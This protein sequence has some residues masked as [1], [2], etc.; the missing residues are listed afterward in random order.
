VQTRLRRVCLALL[1]AA[2]FTVSGPPAAP[3]VGPAAVFPYE[4]RETTL[5]NGLRLVVIP[6]D[7]PGTIAYYTLVRTGSRDDVDPGHSGFAHFFEHMMFRGT[8]KYPAERYKG[9]LRTMGAASNA[10][11][12]A[13]RTLFTILG[14]ANALEE[15]MEME[16]DRFK[17][18]AYTEEDFRTEALAVLGEYNKDATSPDLPLDERL[19]GLAFPHHPYGHDPLGV[20]ADIKAMAGSYEYSRQFF[21]RFYRPENCILLVVG[22]VQ[23]Q[24]AV[25]LAERFYGDWKPGYRAPVVPAEPPQQEMRTAHIDWPAPVDPMLYE[26]YRIPAFSTRTVDSAALKLIEQL[27][28][29][30]SAPLYQ[31]L[32]AEKQWV[33]ELRGTA[34]SR[35][36]PFLLFAFAQARS[37]ALIPR[38]EE[39]IERAIA[40]LQSK[41]VAAERLARITSHLRHAFVLSLETPGAVAEHVAHFLA[42]TGEVKALN[43]SYE[44]YGQVT[45][46]DI[47]RVARAVFRPQN[48]TVVTLSHAEAAAPAAAGLRAAAAP[49]PGDDPAAAVPAVVTLPS[50]R[51]PQVAV[52]LLFRAGSI[53]DP[54]GKEGLAALTALMVANAGS[55]R[56][57]HDEVL[58]QLYPLAAAIRSVTDREVTLFAGRVASESLDSYTA[59]LEEALLTPGFAESDFRRNQAQLLGYLTNTLRSGN[60]ELLGLEVIQDVIFAGQ[61][62]GHPPS[63]TVAGLKSIALEDVRQFY[64]AHYTRANLTIGIAGGYPEGF[65]ARLA[66]DLAALPA[67]RSAPPPPLPPPPTAAGRRITLID[68]QTASVGIHFGFPLPVTRKDPDYYPLMVANSFLGEHRTL[69]GRLMR[70]LRE[71]R[72]LN[73]GDYSYLEYWADPPFTTRPAP[74]VPRRQQYFSVWVRP[75]QPADAQ[76]ALRGALYQVQQLYD[77]GM[78]REEFEPTRDFLI[79]YSKLW[80]QDLSSRLGFYM[81]SRFYGMPYFIDEIETR[82]KAL[83]VEEVNRAIHK[84]LSPENLHAVLVTAGASRLAEL[85]RRDEPS[86]RK[87]ERQMPASVLAADQEIAGIKVRPTAITVVPADRLFEN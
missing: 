2:S 77:Q 19:L 25:G 76:F 8:A 13:D 47:Q 75:V 40:D 1:G 43:E 69:N 26:G 23:P 17:N 3:A 14:P 65:A 68:K 22:D 24:R 32:V 84:Y 42:M 45:P 64:R 50:P 4:V 51:S 20:L 44:S 78:T 36:D 74:N 57:S 58:E 72:G 73:Y 60:D 28:F 34:D 66:H 12:A 9:L 85:L 48:R 30:E 41:P 67:G 37:A 71:L 33:E 16:S 10:N 79:S 56:R 83:S 38:I 11:T 86:P 31:E 15:L 55:A 70:E 7:S 52:R 5:A 54:P 49:P 80:A 6:Y 29:A 63:G 62:Y 46:G 35:R 87:Y 21:A 27:L 59:L 39:S 61:P 53:D 82:L 18:L 81:D